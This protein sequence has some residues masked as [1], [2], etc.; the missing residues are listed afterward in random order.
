V[1]PIAALQTEY[2]LWSRDLEARILPAAREL[3]IGLVAYSPLG[4]G[5][6]TGAIRSRADLAPD[7][8]R[9]TNPR[10]SEENFGANLE[11]VERIR[12]LAGRKGCTP[13]QL[14]L[15]W[16][17]SRGED[18][19]PIPGTR[20]AERLEENAGATAVAL[21]ADDLAELEAVTSAVEVRGTRY[22][23]AAMAALE[24]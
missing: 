5:F 2:S 24:D 4:R 9:L 1:H 23:E 22:P 15:A 10:F 16:V 14:A 20:R 7:D 12:G 17:L 13:A 8:W 3:G 21:S 11:L 19:V 18:V 6:L